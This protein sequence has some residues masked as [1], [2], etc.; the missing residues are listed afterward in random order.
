MI[1]KNKIINI[2]MINIYTI[3]WSI[4]I[5]IIITVLTQIYW[6]LLPEVFQ[7]LKLIP[8]KHSLTTGL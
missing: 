6:N 5:V 8:D 3:V 7:C 4:H 1:D 2:Y